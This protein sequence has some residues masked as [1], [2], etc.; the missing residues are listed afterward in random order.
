MKNTIV[1]DDEVEKALDWL[2]DN[3]SDMGEARRLAVKSDHMLKHIRALAMKNSG[4]NSAAAQEREALAS[5]LYLKAIEATAS[6]AGELERM[7]ALRE[8]AAL[9]IE[10]WR[11]EQAN[12]RAMKI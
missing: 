11:S 2:R 10:T 8:A 7:R 9:K 1:T 5:D 6:A 4:E 12:Y 3:A